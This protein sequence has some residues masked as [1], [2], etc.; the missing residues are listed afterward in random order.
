MTAAVLIVVFCD[1]AACT[2]IHEVPAM[3]MEN[4]LTCL[5]KGQ[6]HVARLPAQP[7]WRLKSWRCGA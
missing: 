3:R 2:R 6:A 7:G 1:I 4:V 5:L